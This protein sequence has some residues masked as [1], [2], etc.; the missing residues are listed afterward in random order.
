VAQVIKWFC[1]KFELLSSFHFAIEVKTKISLF[2]LPTLYLEI[3]QWIL[4]ENVTL[5]ENVTLCGMDFQK[6]VLDKI[7]KAL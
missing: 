4:M 1:T 7:S 3:L 2:G 6:Y 5:T